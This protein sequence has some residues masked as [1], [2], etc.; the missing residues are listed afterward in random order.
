[1]T[2]KEDTGIFGL[3]DLV[4]VCADVRHYKHMSVLGNMV[5]SNQD[6]MNIKE[7]TGTLTYG[8]CDL[9]QV[10]AEVRL[11]AHACAGKHGHFAARQ[12]EYKGRYWYI[13]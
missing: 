5:I 1:M 2:I 9:V 6:K 8:L 3:C 12:T 10:C 7:D 11:L 13:N 4:Q